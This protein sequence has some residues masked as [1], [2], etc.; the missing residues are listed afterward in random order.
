MFFGPTLN[1]ALIVCLCYYDTSMVVSSG[2]IL[3]SPAH[4][5]SFNTTLGV[6]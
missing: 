2:I 1:S 3:L 4:V 5:C 6:R